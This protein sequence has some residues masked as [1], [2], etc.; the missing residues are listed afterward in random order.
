[1]RDGKSFTVKKFQTGMSACERTQ[2]TP[3]KFREKM[4]ATLFSSKSGVIE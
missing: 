3:I 1:M 4:D 2:K